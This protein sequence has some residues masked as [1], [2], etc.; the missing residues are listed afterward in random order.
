MSRAARSIGVVVAVLCCLVL[1]ATTAAQ[2]HPAAAQAHRT[3]PLEA[4]PPVAPKRRPLSIESLAPSYLRPGRPVRVSGTVLNDTGDVWGDAQVG[5]LVSD[6]PFTSTDAIAAATRADPYEEFAGEQI[7][8]P[9]TF[10]DIGDIAPGQSRSFSFTV[11]YDQLD[12]TGGDGVYWVGAELRVT[13]GDGLR[14]SVARTLT[15]MPQV[16]DAVQAPTVDLAMLWPLLAPVPWNG[17]RFLND[18]LSRQFAAAGRLRMLAELGASAGNDPLTW[19][20]DPAVLDAARRMAS[21]YLLGGRRVAADS[22]RAASAA[23]WTAIVRN[24]LGSTVALAVPYGN[25]DVAALAHAN[26]RPGVRRAK[27][28]GERVLDSLGVA[29]L[30]L[31]WPTT[32]RADR[33]VLVK[34]QETNAGVAMLSRDTFAEPPDAAVVDLPAVVPRAG[35]RTT[36][37]L[38]TLVVERD[39]ARTGLRA[40]PGQSTLQWRQL[41]LA[42]TALRSLYGGP[43]RRTAVA[44]PSPLWWPDTAWRDADLFD[45]LQVPWVEQV[46]AS[47]LVDGPHPRY[48]GAL[49]YPDSAARR[50]LGPAIMNKVRR[51]RRTARTV[52][53]LVAD[54]EAKQA[55]TD[56]AFGLSTSAAWRDDRQTGR[57]I[58]RDFVDTNRE[59][60]RSIELEAPNFVT[61]SSD[62]GRFPIS[63]TNRLGEPVTVDL[64]VTARDPRVTVAPI[65]PVTLQR[66]Q[67]VTVT[68]LTSSRGVGITTLTARMLTQTGRPFGPVATF[69]VRITQIGTLVWVIMG[70]GAA[71]LF[72]AAG[73]RIVVRVRGH[74]RRVRGAR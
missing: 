53:N 52:G 66:D 71:I 62:S 28:A 7:L 29:R 23:Q 22:D 63:I 1:A 55:E 33:D 32:G 45:G 44:M 14:A 72:I 51:L 5:M 3:G 47:S 67:R 37:T 73:R 6:S 48:D 8:A 39:Q 43:Q 64:S 69:Q 65:Q 36:S 2:A 17:E 59:M 68:V 26:I 4:E 20:L 10:D 40:Q 18:S 38:P 24:A 30:G 27:R 58:A 19:V 25:P 61:L 15:F 56:R 31:L 41:I 46:T 42:N 35:P 54:P 16:S 50:E 74:R 34:A 12:L 21:G 9:G 11:P 49:T 60:I 57:R 70:V 13:D